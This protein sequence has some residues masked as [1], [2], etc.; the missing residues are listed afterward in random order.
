MNFFYKFCS[1]DNTWRTLFIIIIFMMYSIPFSKHYYCKD[2]KS[3]FSTTIGNIIYPINLLNKCP[4]CHSEDI[5]MTK[6]ANDFK[7]FLS[8]IKFKIKR[9]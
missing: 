8:F 4:Y 7:E 2:C 6:R 3:Y 9:L 1:Y 5:I